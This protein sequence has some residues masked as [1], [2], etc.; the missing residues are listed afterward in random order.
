MCSVVGRISFLSQARRCGSL[1]SV[2]VEGVETR[3]SNHSFGRRR[4]ARRDRNVHLLE[5]KNNTSQKTEI[6]LAAKKGTAEGCSGG[7]RLPKGLGCDR[8]VAVGAASHVRGCPSATSAV[9]D[10]T[11]ARRPVLL[12]TSGL[13][14]KFI[15]STDRPRLCQIKLVS[16]NWGFRDLCGTCWTNGNV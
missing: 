5:T 16:S 1:A 2:V 12:A 10:P 15:S 9:D 13:P 8:G 7:A 11:P 6:V 3:G 4:D 14:F